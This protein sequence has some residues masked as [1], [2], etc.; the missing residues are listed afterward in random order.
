MSI[1][2][3]SNNT[4]K[5]YHA[6]LKHFSK[7]LEKQ[8]HEIPNLL[9]KLKDGLDPYR[10]LNDFVVYLHK[11]GLKPK[12][13]KLAVT[14]TKGYLRYSGIKIY[15]EEFKQI[16]KLPKPR[17]YREEPLTKEIL[18][19][20]LRNFPT[21]LQTVVLVAVSSG[22]RIGEIVQL[23]ISDIDFESK[24]VIIRI[25]AETTKTKESRETFLTTEATKALK[26]YLQRFYGWK[27]GMTNQTIRNNLVFA[28]VTKARKQEDKKTN[29]PVQIASSVLRNSL[30]YHVRKI[31]ELDQRNE[32]DVHI[33]HFHAFRKFFYTTV[34][35]SVGS[36]YANALLGHR[37][38]LDTY[39]NLPK[40]KRREM[41]LKAEPHLTIS[42]FTKV[43]RDLIN[44]QERQNEIEKDHLEL[45]RMLK[46]GPIQYPKVLEKYVK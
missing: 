40:E 3:G 36:D 16:V 9:S 2:S 33:I 20:L 42:D 26:D 5:A 43:E 38:Y 46:Q 14:A 27:E 19:R 44:V 41:Y 13:I 21:K 7:F 11:L 6:G 32:N 1:Q 34:S 22:M 30:L 23:K 15:N 45:L 35:N 4:L 24:P 10:L 37:S 28:P 29:T 17:R 25:R 12:T 8:N 39:Y 18:V 31:P